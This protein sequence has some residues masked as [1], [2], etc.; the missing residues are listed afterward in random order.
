MRRT[1]ALLKLSV[2][3]LC[4]WSIPLSLS[5]DAHL[6]Q[7]PRITDLFARPSVRR[8]ELAVDVQITGV[9]T[10]GR[11]D[12]TA[13]LLDETGREEKQFTV[14]A[15]LTADDKQTVTVTI[16]WAKPR[17]W[18]LGKPNLYTLDLSIHGPGID[19]EAKQQFGFREFWVEGKRLYLNGK[20]I[21]I[22]PTHAREIEA[23]RRAG[24]NFTLLEPTVRDDA[25][26]REQDESWY[27]RADAAGWL[28]SG[29]TLSIAPYLTSRNAVSAWS[30]DRRN[31]W[32]SRVEAQ[33]RR[34]RNHP[35]I[36]MWCHSPDLFAAAA[37]TNPRLIG[38][39]AAGRAIAAGLAQAGSE[40]CDAM[41][42]IDPTRPVCPYGGGALGD[43]FTVDLDLGW[44]PLQEREDW[45]TDWVR[46]GDMPT[47][48][49]DYG[50]PRLANY[51]RGRIDYARALATEPLV[52]EYAAIYFGPLAYRAETDAYR[53]AYAAR[54]LSGQSYRFDNARDAALLRDAP[55]IQSVEALFNRNILRSWRTTG[56]T[57]GIAPFLSTPE[58]TAP[59]TDG[60]E[61]FSA[62]NQ[63][64][65][66]WITGPFDAPTA[67]THSYHVDE[68]VEK[69][70]CL[71]N[72]T[73]EPLPYSYSWRAVLNG[74]TIATGG[75]KGRLDPAQTK[76][77]PLR[78][79]TPYFRISK[80]DGEIL[81]TARIGEASHQ[82]RLAYRVF[83]RRE[84]R[85]R[86]PS[87]PVFD[88]TG[89]T[90]DLLP[91]VDFIP[92]TWH[93]ERT[94][95]LVI[96][97]QNALSSGR[98]LPANLENFVRYGGRLLIFSQKQEW[99]E[100]QLGMRTAA[101][102]SRRVFPVR[103]THPVARGLDAYDLRDWRGS[104][105]VVPAKSEASETV[106]PFGWHWGNRGAVCSVSIEKP[107]YGS[108]TPLLENEWDMA[109][110]PLMELNY[111]KG[112]V[113][114][115]N[116]DLEDHAVTDAAAERVFDRIL[117]YALHA[118]LT[119]KAERV[120]YVG[121]G[122]DAAYL[123]SLGVTFQSAGTRV[124]A[125]L[126]TGPSAP[127]L[128]L[129]GEG[130]TVVKE[131]L[132]RYL[133][134]GGLAM[135]LGDAGDSI[136]AVTQPALSHGSLERP[137]W[138]VCNGLS[139]SDLHWRGRISVSAIKSLP[140]FGP[141]TAGALIGA[142]G[143]LGLVKVG[144]GSALFCRID[145]RRFDADART[146]LRTSRWRATRAVCQL[147]SNMG[148]TF[149]QDARFFHAG[150]TAPTAP[151]FYHPDY[152]SDFELGDNP[153]RYLNW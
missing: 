115:C 12:V 109:Y 94:V 67:K 92:R 19:A 93:G 153:Y 84:R 78:F 120:R 26:E 144:K 35:S 80:V 18:D 3:S 76:F 145:P 22:R 135:F 111:G 138:Q 82:D 33:L 139:L 97:G 71:I 136:G 2:I 28:T 60:W 6:P 34:L 101:H 7:A 143:L 126:L 56:L 96:I 44:L 95:P 127:E 83:A 151:G 102:P 43:I 42:R 1:H 36:V 68:T 75:G 124:D 86:P 146:Y 149:Q 141:G 24:Y 106:P 89:K 129:V 50:A 104:S 4:V 81:L 47:M 31:E 8:K 41:R 69:Q 100:Q 110:T 134:R 52:T 98:P 9:P 59:A 55:A 66:A 150:E 137:D 112:R 23:N 99:I 64:T 62:N 27:S 72:D 133:D 118:P 65:L 48:A 17:L 130:A 29:R 38:R 148:A 122:A 63:S 53:D 5:A 21:R 116:L 90:G 61:A 105:M 57:G 45:F 25:P 79:S 87:L 128:L 114:W 40:A 49:V 13:R 20:P 70:V 131:D 113:I 85:D 108:W 132:A 107:H 11:A 125:A 32:T 119:P 15:G 10:A 142:D 51:L 147:L 14:E 46:A 103:E 73:R 88:P 58:P 37:D 123:E 39:K 91:V 152:R 117:S 121:N 30:V 16:P 77:Q 54:F 140:T 74:R